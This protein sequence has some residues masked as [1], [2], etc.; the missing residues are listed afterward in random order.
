MRGYT[1]TWQAPNTEAWRTVRVAVGTVH[2][3]GEEQEKCQSRGCVRKYCKAMH[4]N[5]TDGKK[6]MCV[7]V[8]GK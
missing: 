5:Y 3:E 1:Q 6:A 7:H 2:P 4:G 8:A